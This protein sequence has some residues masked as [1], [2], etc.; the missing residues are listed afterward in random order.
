M[1]AFSAGST[2]SLSLDEWDILTVIGQARLTI[3]VSGQTPFDTET[4]GTQVIGPFGVTSTISLL[5]IGIGTYTQTPSG[6]PVMVD[7]VDITTAQRDAPTAAMLA[8]TSTLYQL[9]AAP[10]TIYRSNGTTLI[11]LGAG[12]SGGATVFAELDDAATAPIA[13]TNTSVAAI[14]TTAD[15][16][17]AAVATKAPGGEVVVYS[18]TGRSLADTDNGDVVRCTNVGAVSM[19]IPTGLASGF[20]CVL[21]QDGGV[22]TVSASGT[23]LTAKDSLSTSGAQSMLAVVQGTSA[24]AYT[25]VNSEPTGTA[26]LAGLTDIATYNLAANNTSLATAL[27]GKQ[28]TLVSATNIKSIN[29][30]SILG[31]GNLTVSSTSSAVTISATAPTSPSSGQGWISTMTGIHYKWYEQ[32]AGS[33]WVEF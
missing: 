29:G 6:V 10:F 33:A 32:G 31:T 19:V 8:S 9:N 1:A 26:S 18:G 5:G 4:Y 7:M 12:D 24:N 22:V 27:A 30:Q 15:A 23:T 21:V 13:T 11:S 17:A 20:S 3:T 16:A 14:K 28:A 25:V 2:A